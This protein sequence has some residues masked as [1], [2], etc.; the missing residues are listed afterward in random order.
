M[1]AVIG[2]ILGIIW[3]LYFNFSIVLLY[4]PVIVSIYFFKSIQKKF[5]SNNK[6]K[7]ISIKR[8]F[9]YFK[10]YFTFKVIGIIFIS[11]I[12]SNTILILK[13]QVYNSFY[14]NM[15]QIEAVGIV[16]SNKEEKEYKNVYKI[17]IKNIN[18]IN[19]YSNVKIYLQLKKDSNIDLKYGDM[20][21]FKG[22]Y[23]KPSVQRNYGGF[24]YSQYLKTLGIYGTVNSEKIEI[25]KN[26]TINSV[27][28]ISNQISNSIKTNIEK[29]LPESEANMLK[30]IL[31]G[32]TENLDEELKE[33]FRISNIAHI[34]AVSGMHVSYLIIAINIAFKN[35]L[36]KRKV[37]ILS[38][39]VLVIYMFITGF[40]PSIVRATI[41]G[42]ILLTSKLIHVRN[43][44]WEALSL[45]LIIILLYNPY[46]IINAGLQLSYFGT[47]GIYLFNK[48]IL[49]FLKNAKI[50]N[51]KIRHRINK[52]ITL[53]VDKLKEILSVIIS[54]QIAILPITLFHFNYFGI[55]FFITNIL[56][57][58]IIG[59]II[60]LGFA[61]V[62]LSYIFFPLVM[63]LTIIL[64][65]LLKLLKQI[66]D[67]SQL[68]FS[69]IYVATPSIKI[70]ILYFCTVLII[71]F[72]FKVYHSEEIN[73]TYIRIKNLISLLKYNFNKNKNKHIKIIVWIGLFIIIFNLIPQNL[74]INFVDV[75]QGDS[76]F[77]I[78]PHGKTILIDGGGGASKTFDVGKST[79]LPSILDKGYTKIDYVI[80]S[81]F[82][83]DH[84]R[85]NFNDY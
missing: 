1:I 43:D 40:S 23:I 6:F 25:L 48:N 68:P 56:V 74:E 82:D 2:Y 81:H 11:S 53:I 27:F 71:N 22:K 32:D 59:I 51:K 3:G 69:K 15:T 41:M 29:M 62:I 42:I 73:L 19:K 75:G 79:L 64:E 28:T 57:T 26:S 4:I 12:I 70:I 55:Y 33:Q 7:L 67:F 66:T 39:L 34:L 10:I 45:S 13:N 44:M 80:I 31:L 36:G 54:A 50:K 78:T 72:L 76:S 5:K 17:K 8:Y 65:I 47:I 85:W 21:K 38:I 18:K 49:N 16:I 58:M 52:K 35:I 24:D 61:L 9:R 84:V 37:N 46:L 83:D 14:N 30:G 20:I 63:K 60:S 77:I